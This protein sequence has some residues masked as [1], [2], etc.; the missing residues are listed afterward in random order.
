MNRHLL[1]V[2]CSYRLA[3][4]GEHGAGLGDFNISIQKQT[5]REKKLA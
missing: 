1:S 3:F 2:V 5:S 4:E